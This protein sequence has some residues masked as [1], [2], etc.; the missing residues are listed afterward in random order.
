M[1]F[2]KLYGYFNIKWV[3]LAALFVFEVGSLICGVAPNSVTLIVG[4]AIAG[5]GS[6]GL[7]AGALITI[8]FSTPVE[9]RPTYIGMIGAMYG[10]ASV[11]GPLVR[12]LGDIFLGLIVS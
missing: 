3:F 12:S 7:F 8:A 11:A 2:G 4:R 10:L 5:L 9:T 1:L 6:A